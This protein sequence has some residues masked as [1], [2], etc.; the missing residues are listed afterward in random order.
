MHKDKAFE[1]LKNNIS[2]EEEILDFFHASKIFNIWLFV[3]MG[4]LAVLTIKGYFVAVTNKGLHFHALSLLGKFSQHDFFAYTEIEC[5]KIGRGILQIP[6]KFTFANGR[7]L[8]IRAQKTGVNSVAK[9]HDK[10]LTF[11]REVIREDMR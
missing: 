4:P 3:L 9:V 1:H 8:K 2:P 10:T 5:V 6:M 7:K 11:L